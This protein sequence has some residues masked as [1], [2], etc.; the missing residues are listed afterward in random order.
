MCRYLTVLFPLVIL[1]AG[2]S[3]GPASA[4]APANRFAL[5]VGNASYDA[6]ALATPANDAALIAQT[7]QAAG[8]HVARANDLKQDALRKAFSDFAETLAKAG[9]DTVAFVY[10][11]GY[12]LQLGGETFLLPVDARIAQ[13]SDVPRSGVQLSDLVRTLA[14]LHLKETILILDAA[15]KS[16]FLLAGVPPSGGLAW[17]EPSADTLVAFN[18]AP[19]TVSPDEGGRY[20]SYARAIA[21]MLQQGGLAPTETFLLARLR[22]NELTRGAQVPWH[23]SGFERQFPLVERRKDAPQS[24]HSLE[25]VALIRSQTMAAL[26]PQQAYSAVLIRDTFDAYADYLADHG[27]GPMAKRVR[28]LLAARREAITWWRSCEADVPDAYWTYLERYPS[29]AHGVDARR[30]LEKLGASIVPPAKF[31]SREYDVPPPLPDELDYV[32]RPALS[33]AD[34]E[35]SS[36]PAPTFRDILGDPPE[37]PGSDAASSSKASV[38]AA[39]SAPQPPALVSPSDAG[40]PDSSLAFDTAQMRPSIDDHPLRPVQTVPSP[41]Q[42][43]NPDTDAAQPAAKATPAIE[44]GKGSALSGEARTSAGRLATSIALPLWAK[45]DFA[46]A[47]PPIGKSAASI[48]LPAPPAWASREPVAPVGDTLSTGALADAPPAMPVPTGLARQGRKWI[49][50]T[51]E[52]SIPLPVSRPLGRR[53]YPGRTGPATSADPATAALLQSVVSTRPAQPSRLAAGAAAPKPR[54]APVSTSAPQP[55][56]RVGSP[57]G[58]SSTVTTNSR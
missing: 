56:A 32:S 3:P 35:F 17:L 47:A 45:L 57:G 53:P 7:L 52:E 6:K 40:S 16:P 11:A 46:Q 27:R 19:G 37:F 24:T 25:A 9:P 22:V 50:L 34:P 39:T 15:R 54:R 42:A 23:A 31:R 4:A 55:S 18:A 41:T 8:F 21:E 2:L 29:G 20:G 10:F 44:P 38:P 26:A 33:L 28:A 58:I 30:R 49:M 5:V 36:E 43:I 13:A 12:G 48:D 14:T 1:L 51:P